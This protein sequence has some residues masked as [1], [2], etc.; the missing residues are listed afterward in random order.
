MMVPDD[1]PR[2]Y[3]ALALPESALGE[4]GLEILR[5]GIINDALHISARRGLQEQAQWGEVLADVAKHIAGL[6]AAE[7]PGLIRKD[8]T[9]EIAQAF[10]AAIGMRPVK[11]DAPT[12][13]VSR[14]GGAKTDARPRAETR[15]KT[16]AK[17]RA[18]P[19]RRTR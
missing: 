5:V 4:G 18:K 7:V 1:D 11:D 16:G 9:V 10:A 13:P 2:V 19:T 15:A 17:S 14:R 8:V 3:Q 6:Y 12:P